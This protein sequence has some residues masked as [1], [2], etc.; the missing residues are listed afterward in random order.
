MNL[1]PHI[2]IREAAR[3]QALLDDPRNYAWRAI[4]SEKLVNFTPDIG[5][6][7]YPVPSV[8]RTVAGHP[9]QLRHRFWQTVEGQADHTGLRYIGVL[10]YLAA[11]QEHPLELTL[12]D[13]PIGRV[14]PKRADN[15]PHLIVA[16]RAVEFIGEMEV[17][18][19]NAA[20][21]GAYRIET[22][23]LLR[24]LPQ[25][26]R[27]IPR[28]D[29]LRRR[30]RRQG[31]GNLSAELY[32]TTALV[33]PI[34]AVLRDESGA[35]V[36]R[37]SGESGRLHQLRFDGLLPDRC[38]SVAVAARDFA[39]EIDAP[40]KLDIDT[41][42]AARAN[43]DI[44]VPLEICA[45]GANMAGLPL[46][47]GLPF[48]RGAVSRIED[49]RLQAGDESL[50]ASAKIQSRWDDGSAQWALFRTR[51]PEQTR[52]VALHVNSGRTDEAASG[53]GMTLDELRV[54][55][56]TFE[57]VLGNGEKLESSEIRL[58]QRSD[59]S[60]VFLVE[61]QDGR[62]VTQLR[63]KLWLRAYAGQRFIT[64]RHRLEV[65]APDA[66]AN[67]DEAAQ[68]LSLRQFSLRMPFAARRVSHAGADYVLD[69]GWQ[70]R[71]DHDLAHELCGE[72][73]EGRAQGHIRVDGYGGSLGVG[74]RHFWQTYPK[75]LTVDADGIELGFFPE[76]R[77]RDLPG[78]EDAPHRLYFWLDGTGY[79]LKAGLALS[80]DILLDWS[81]DE[82]LFDWL[83]E[84]PLARPSAEYVNGCGVMPAMG[85][86]AD[87]PMPAYEELTDSA[88]ASFHS[89]RERHRAYGQLN[90]GDWYGESGWSWG[91]NE[92]DSAYCGYT[93]F[94]RGGEAGWA[95][96]AAE[97]ARH[98]ADVDTV[99]TAPDAL[100]LGGQ[101]MHIPG[102]LGGY[103]PPYFRSKMRGTS[104]IPSHNWVEGPLL[105]WLLTG[106]EAAYESLQKTRLWLL[107][108]RFF[109]AYDFTNA[110]EAGWHLI[111]LCAFAS[112]DDCAAL[113]AAALLVS[114]VLERQEPGG[115]WVRMLTDSHCG[116]GYPRCRGATGFM[117]GVLLSGLMRYYRLTQDEAVA[118]AIVGGARWLIRHTFDH[119]SGHFRYTSCANR[120]LG[121]KFQ[122]TQ[123]ALEG[124][125][126]AW[127]CSG[128]EEIGGYLSRGLDV[129][130]RFPEGIYHSGMGKA[131]AQ[132][133]RYVPSIL[134]TLQ[135]RPV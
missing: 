4:D 119:E 44:S 14:E 62:G 53:G 37:K 66:A 3:I 54:D 33:A 50:P 30:L 81:G 82:R 56:W 55:N 35:K 7:A 22:V 135:S 101:A 71:H 26:S 63:S 32:F 47:I 38:Y 100:R 125:A 74:L 57:A 95:H 43:A 84:P 48:A 105:H 13:M 59:S 87:S 25:A 1:L 111:H 133:M 34:E 121:G 88:L 67:P 65:I 68:M 19:I 79:K 107:Q 28:I 12:G 15:R 126:A 103:L 118:D 17:L 16:R 86:R 92:Y 58:L 128:D 39:G 131:F 6:S 70:L 20:G 76:R 69:G 40:A 102:H 134:G 41:A 96:W 11:G 108:K 72:T 97:A 99:N 122:C 129:I 120:T 46:T 106:D 123:W 91:N 78:D 29:N 36:A 31:D 114:R 93:E 75:A 9:A 2:D 73:R 85:A 80:S 112:L 8:T 42:T 116:C 83:E 5:L 98:L 90:Y 18:Q 24:D 23:A 104:L 77:G 49:C 130:G 115:G 94:L 64:L 27:Y 61:H 109:D 21:D 124:L 10:I 60:A 132:Q 45:D 127:S 113:N 110:R 117:V 51:A 52:A 89:D